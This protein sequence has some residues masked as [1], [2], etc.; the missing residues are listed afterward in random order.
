M[1]IQDFI[2][3]H[4]KKRLDECKSLVIY[5]P[6]RIYR[7]IALGLSS[8]DIT[9]VD[10]SAS[11]IIGRE[12]ALDAWCRLAGADDARLV[13]YLP[14][15]RPDSDAARQ[16]EPYQIFAL[17]G[18]EFPAAEGEAYDALCRQAAP[19]LGPRIDELFASGPPDF[20]TVNH[21]LAGGA[22]WPKLKTLLGAESAVEI[23]TAVLSPSTDQEAALSAD[24]GWLPELK[25]FLRSVLDLRLKT[26]SIRYPTVSSEIWRFV[27]FSEFA[28]DLPGPLPAAL[29]DVP[30]ASD[31]YA[32]LIF[33]VC[34]QLRGAEPHQ[35]VYMEQSEQVAA[36]LSLEAHAAGITDLGERDTFAFEER[37]YLQVFVD[38]VLA[39]DYEAASRIADQRSRSIWIRHQGERQQLWTV[40][41]RGLDLLTAANDCLNAMD[42]VE[43]RGDTLFDFY[44]KS[45]R[46]ADQRHREFEQ[47]VTDTYGEL[48]VLERVV[49]LAR[50]RYLEAAEALQRRFLAAVTA[51]GWP[52]SGRVRH[53]E[54]FDRFLAPPLKDRRK[55]AFFMVDALRYEL[56]AELTEKLSLKWTSEL[57]PVC[58]QLPTVTTVGMAALMPGAD[59]QLK[60]VQEKGELVPHVKGHRVARPADRFQ[61]IKEVYGDRAQMR[62]LDDIVTKKIRLPETVHLLLVKTTDID[63]FG[64]ISPLEARRLIPRLTQKILAAIDRTRKLGFHLAVI[65]TDHGF[66]LFDD[67]QAGDGVPRPDGEWDM[68]KTRCLLGKAATTA[69]VRVFSRADVGIQGDFEDFVV[70]KGFGTF[71]QGHPY[72]H[73][74]LSLQE[75]VLPVIQIDFDKK[76]QESLNTN[77]E[78]ALT[79]K[80]GKSDRVTTRRPMIEVMMF[81]AMFKET[82]EIQLVALA[83]LEVVGEVAAS[84]HVNPATN[85]I[86]M[87]PGQAIKVPLKM[88]EEFHGRFE[89]RAVDPITGV[90]YAT[91]SLTTDYLE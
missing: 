79:Y 45:F 71:I 9:V 80:G 10:G 83:G 17:G 38:A 75:C 4:F 19:D 34:D 49:T 27:L 33:A 14:V 42:T 48:D 32:D 25:A 43:N 26:R 2:G 59:G 63:Q 22:T 72:A 81:S 55:V 37:T 74:G 91:L 86:S 24:S 87:E 1:R 69:H 56:A 90:N 8:D 5:D 82:I 3:K 6:A 46:M 16:A 67:Q 68:A 35:Q 60:L 36:A 23:L 54:V 52:V 66:V 30:R 28:L 47:A 40:A 76:G 84:Q 29:K 65:A 85:M 61:F 77:I 70:P 62:D 21:L 57:T 12:M 13:V 39:E 73:G 89:V 7:E 51:E 31:Q 15:S 18:G 44:C 41:V 78:I 50:R 53:G 20:Q 11:T 58:A 88:A 64:E